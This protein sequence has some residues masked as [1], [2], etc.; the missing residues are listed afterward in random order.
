LQIGGH[1]IKTKIARQIRILHANTAF[2]A[3]QWTM[4]K[5][6]FAHNLDDKKNWYAYNKSLL[7][8]TFKCFPSEVNLNWSNVKTCET[9]KVAKYRIAISLPG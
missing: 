9:T 1:Y 3:H 7:S 2:E 8:K 6:V 4:F 5:R